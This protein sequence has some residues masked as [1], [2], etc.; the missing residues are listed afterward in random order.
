MW[1]KFRAVLQP[2]PSHGMTDKGLLECFYRG[3]G[4]ENRDIADQLCEGDMLH[5]PY[6]VVAKLLDGMV[7]ANKEAKKKQE[8]D[9]L[10]TQLNALSTRVTELEVQAMGKEKHS[11][12]QECKNGKKQRVL[13]L[14]YLMQIDMLYG[15][16]VCRNAPIVKAMKQQSKDV[17]FEFNTRLTQIV[18]Q[19]KEQGI[20]TELYYK[21]KEMGKDTFSIIPTSAIRYEGNQF[22][23]QKGRFL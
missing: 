3:L 15:W 22:W 21:N 11:S 4:P 17:Q 6:E 9:V 13:V 7:E 5:Q 2:C 20:N 18:T 12:L 10:V 16:K 14:F 19:F 23:L 1:L 8:W